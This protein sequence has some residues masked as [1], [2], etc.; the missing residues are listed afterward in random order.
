MPTKFLFFL[1][2]STFISLKSINAQVADVG[3]VPAVFT[4]EGILIVEKVHKSIIPGYE[5]QVKKDFENYKGKYI[6][7]TKKEF[8]TDSQ[9]ADKKNYRFI[10]HLKWY[11]DRGDPDLKVRF[12]FF[13]ED[14]ETG[15]IYKGIGEKR[16]GPDTIEHTVMM[17]NANCK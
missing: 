1:S 3:P 12:S 8:E 6:V 14:R 11:Q 17:L 4:C 15:N 5:K 16:N 9:F 13:L 10:L 7:A 2:I